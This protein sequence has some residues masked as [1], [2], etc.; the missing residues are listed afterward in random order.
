MNATTYLAQPSRPKGLGERRSSLSLSRYSWLAVLILVLF[1]GCGDPNATTCDPAACKGCCDSSGYCH[2]DD[3]PLACGANGNQCIACNFGDTCQ[4][5]LCIRRQQCAPKS[6]VELQK[7]C[8][9]V[10]D[11]CGGV[12]QCGNCEAPGESCGGAGT[13]NV[14]GPGTCVAKTCA[15]LGKNCGTLSDG[16]SSI[17]NCGTCQSAQV[18]GGDGEANVC[19]TM[20]CTAQTCHSLGA[21]CGTVP[22]GC[23]KQLSCGTC[24]VSGE[25]CGGGGTKNVCGKGACTPKNCQQLGKNCDMADDGCGNMISCGTCQGFESCGGGGMPGVCG[26]ACPAGSVG[27]FV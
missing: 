5:G 17:L 6:C 3:S 20:N 11:G 25:S 18:C 1:A 12:L 13:S 7:N 8:G 4:L 26:A 14:C 21:N 2:A 27:N 9:T 15:G 22:D 24:M 19:S 16:C 23:G 10:D